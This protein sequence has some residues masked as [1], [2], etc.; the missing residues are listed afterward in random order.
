M[1]QAKKKPA[2]KTASAKS[3][4]PA[5]EKV[6]NFTGEVQKAQEEIFSISR[7]GVEN[8]TE[9]AEK[10]SKLI[11]EGVALSRDNIE[12]CVECSNLAASFSKDISAEISE[13]ANKA[14]SDN[15]E[16]AKEFFACRT[17]NDIVELQNRAA[18]NTLDNFFQ[19]S[20]A[21]SNLFFEYGNEAL[22]PINERVSKA[23]QQIS[24]TLAA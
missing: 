14:F 22:E 15:V 6:I 3:S 17:L 5:S 13:S 23:T 24:K 10:A 16:L 9:S 4:K 7:E 20:F 11:S 18:K 21:F 1:A 8:L 12:A 2:A 19:Q